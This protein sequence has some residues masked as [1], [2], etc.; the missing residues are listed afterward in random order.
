MP[1][2]V[3]GRDLPGLP[4]IAVAVRVGDEEVEGTAG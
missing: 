4:G 1:L 3:G 2:R